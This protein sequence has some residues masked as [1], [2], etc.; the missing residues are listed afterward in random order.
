MAIIRLGPLQR[1][2]WGCT[3]SEFAGKGHQIRKGKPL[4]RW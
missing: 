4:L 1:P 3:L 2:L